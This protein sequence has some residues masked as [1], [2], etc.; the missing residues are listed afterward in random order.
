[1]LVSSSSSN[2]SAS[3]GST[4]STGSGSSGSVVTVIA[5]ADDGSHAPGSAGLPRRTALMSNHGGGGGDRPLSVPPAPVRQDGGGKG[6]GNVMQSNN[7]KSVHYG[8]SAPGG[9]ASQ[10]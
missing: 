3:T 6:V 7:T 2:I 8:P 5:A 10:L 9:A 4:A 1:M